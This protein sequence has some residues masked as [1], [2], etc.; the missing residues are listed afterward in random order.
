MKLKI[1]T[2]ILA[3][4]HGV[5][6]PGAS[7]V[8][9]YSDVVGYESKAFA[10]G[11]TG[12][13]VGFVQAAKFNGPAASI[14]AN[15][16]TVGSNSFAAG[17]FAPVA[18]LP[19]H[20]LQITSG[21][22]EG[23]VVDITGNTGNSLSVGTGD[24]AS[25]A[26]TTPTFVVRPH[27]TISSLFSGNTALTDYSDTITIYNA[28]GSSTTFLRD[29]STASGWLDSSTFSESN[30]VIYPGQAFLL[31]AGGSGSFTVTGQVNPSKTIVPVYATAINFVSLSNPTNGKNVQNIQLGTNL[32]DYSDTV[33][34]FSANR[35]F[36]QDTT[37]LWTVA[38]GFLD[39][40][41]LSPASGVVAG[42]TT[43][44]LISVGADTTWVQPS[45]LTQ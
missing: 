15:T 23:L 16:L 6:V 19:S 40:V 41:T 5:F 4:G 11:T 3:A 44:I 26:G 36:T 13:G 12:H 1:A 35:T 22:Q 18:G 21:P 32:A 7:A 8:E 31:S 9:S 20:Y 45:P 17:A 24:L 27:L 10:S 25:V 43:A 38:E 14:T 42:G 34:L 28:D 2:L 37:L 30:A 39:T 33:G 29:T